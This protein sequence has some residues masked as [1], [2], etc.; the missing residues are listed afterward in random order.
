MLGGISRMTISITVIV[1][2]ATQNISYV[3]PVALTIMVSKIVGDMLSDGI[4]DLHLKI[5]QYPVLEEEIPR[6]RE[7]LLARRTP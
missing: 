5:K 2:E 1:L 6:R 3:L 7:G 4:Y